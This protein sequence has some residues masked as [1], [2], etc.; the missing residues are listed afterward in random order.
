MQESHPC[1]IPQVNHTLSDMDRSVYH[2]GFTEDSYHCV[3]DNLIMQTLFITYRTR[4]D[5]L[6]NSTDKYRSGTTA[7][8][9]K[10]GFSLLDVR[11]TSS[12][13]RG[14]KCH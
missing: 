3:W 8:K 12:S 7:D 5:F 9:K 13:R 2:G 6:R 1:L 10:T 11:G 14:E 4:L